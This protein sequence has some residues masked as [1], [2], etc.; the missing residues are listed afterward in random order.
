MDRAIELRILLFRGNL[1][2]REICF[3]SN[4]RELGLRAPQ[5]YLIRYLV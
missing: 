1:E 4:F 5:D 3:L 2:G